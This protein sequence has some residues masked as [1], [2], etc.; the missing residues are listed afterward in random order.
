MPD[1]KDLKSVEYI[2]PMLA[3]VSRLFGIEFKPTGKL[4]FR[5]YCPFHDDTKDSFRVYVNGKDEVRFRCFGACDCEWDIY[6]LVM[7]REKCDFGKAQKRFADFLGVTDFTPREE[8]PGC[9]EAGS[10]LV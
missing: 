10:Q 5:S 7:L 4:R 8:K 9:S 6:D 1:Y 3:Y 2:E